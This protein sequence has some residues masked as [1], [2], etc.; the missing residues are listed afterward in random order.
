MV[1]WY[2]LHGWQPRSWGL[3]KI[4]P[5]L[6]VT[7]LKCKMVSP[8]LLRLHRSGNASPASHIKDFKALQFLPI[9]KQP[10][11]LAFILIHLCLDFWAWT[12]LLHFE[13]K[14]KT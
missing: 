14:G 10:G 1:L 7:V 4:N 13:R 11:S 2:V 8:S 9:P 3:G 12:W 6:G 5:N